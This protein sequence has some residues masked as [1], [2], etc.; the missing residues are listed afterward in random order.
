MSAPMR[1]MLAGSAAMLCI[2]V[3]IGASA[4]DGVGLIAALASAVA[5]GSGIVM[6]GY[7]WSHR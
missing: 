1:R 5:V 2:A 6:L 4:G 3:A 7:L